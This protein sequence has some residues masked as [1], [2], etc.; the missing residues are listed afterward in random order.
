[1]HAM[2]LSLHQRRIMPR[3]SV[4]RRWHSGSELRPLATRG[5]RCGKLPGHFGFARWT[6]Q[7]EHCPARLESRTQREVSRARSA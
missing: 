1:V 5:E 3:S 4:E 7:T 2:R 6:A